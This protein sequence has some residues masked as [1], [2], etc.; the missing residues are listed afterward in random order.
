M[1]PPVRTH[2]VLVKELFSA[3][4]MEPLRRV[5][6]DREAVISSLVTAGLGV[7]LMRRSIMAATRKAGVLATT[8]RRAI[9]PG[10][11]MMRRLAS[12]DR[13]IVTGVFR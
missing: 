12:N 13:S 8:Q 5:E 3:H 7:A 10:G 4:G 9:L 11:T 1:T 6:A 2:H